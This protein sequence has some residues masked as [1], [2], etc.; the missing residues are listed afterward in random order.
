M[1]SPQ[2]NLGWDRATGSQFSSAWWFADSLS[3]I[4]E[5]RGAMLLCQTS[6][7]I[8]A[9]FLITILPQCPSSRVLGQVKFTPGKTN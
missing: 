4:I 9:V 6:V 2:D 5:N 1:A 3:R 8:L 7:T